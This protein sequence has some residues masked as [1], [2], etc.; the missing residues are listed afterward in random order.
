[1]ETIKVFFVITETSARRSTM[2]P[3]STGR[4]TT[5]WP[6]EASC[7]HASITHLCSVE[8]VMIWHFFFLENPAA[9]FNA[10]LLDSAAPDVKIISRGAAPIVDAIL[11]RADS[12]ASWASWPY[13]CVRE[14]GFPGLSK[15]YGYIASITRGSVGVVDW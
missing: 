15:K 7:R 6:M 13:P 12:T 8:T 11:A 14:W 4:K 9:P 3:G 5:S 10:K 2:P 1:M